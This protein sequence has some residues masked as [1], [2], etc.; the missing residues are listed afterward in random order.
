MIRSSRA[1]HGE[2]FEAGF[3][4]ANSARGSSHAG[5]SSERNSAASSQHDRVSIRALQSLNAHSSRD[6]LP[7]TPE[8]GAYIVTP[9][10]LLPLARELRFDIE[11]HG[12]EISAA[13]SQRREALKLLALWEELEELQSQTR[14]WKEEMDR[15]TRPIEQFR[16]LVGA[17]RAGL[18]LRHTPAVV[19]AEALRAGD[20]PSVPSVPPLVSALKRPDAPAAAE[21]GCDVGK[22]RTNRVVRMQTDVPKPPSARDEDPERQVP[23]LDTPRTRG[24]SFLSV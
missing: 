13:A 5:A 11:S 8:P 20:T 14:F 1:S 18:R 6:E 4:A 9:G 24:V 17:V 15:A 12:E 10:A 21:H 22:T 23:V 19:K 16:G 7:V 2:P 3:I